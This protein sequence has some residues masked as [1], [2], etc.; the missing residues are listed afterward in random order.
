MTTKRTGFIS[1]Q[2]MTPTSTGSEMNG[3]LIP[4]QWVVHNSKS[5]RNFTLAKLIC[6]GIERKEKVSRKNHPVI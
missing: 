1:I 3:I 4:S 2:Q 5:E 6:K